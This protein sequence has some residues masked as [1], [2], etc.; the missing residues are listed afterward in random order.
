M[1][2]VLVNSS[3]N[4]DEARKK[5]Q[6]YLEKLEAKWQHEPFTDPEII[7]Y[8]HLWDLMLNVVEENQGKLVL[9]E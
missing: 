4:V 5:G 8:E 2:K 1:I 6:K 7:P 3:F 9:Q